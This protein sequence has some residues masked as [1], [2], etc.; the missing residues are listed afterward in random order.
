MPQEGVT[1][2]DTI[3]VQQTLECSDVKSLAKLYLDLSANHFAT[4]SVLQP[5]IAGN[6]KIFENCT[7]SFISE[8]KDNDNFSH[9]Q[10]VEILKIF[11][12]NSRGIIVA[13]NSEYGVLRT[14]YT[15]KEYYKNNFNYVAP[16]QVNFTVP[17]NEDE[18]HY[19]YVPILDT[20]KQ[21]LQN[22]NIRYFVNHR[23][24]SNENCFSDFTDGNIF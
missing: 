19:H 24:P 13:H 10:R 6:T 9:D 22:D 16:E 1:L 18:C 14:T 21:L 20:L 17:E 11:Q 8:I 7:K 3:P 2:S 4:E 15:R 23:K 5:M 12:S